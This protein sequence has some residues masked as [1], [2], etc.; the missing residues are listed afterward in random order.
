MKGF[1]AGIIPW[2][3]FL[4]VTVDETFRGLLIGAAGILYAAIRIIL[5]SG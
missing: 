2:I 4:R 3:G 1:Y 5:N